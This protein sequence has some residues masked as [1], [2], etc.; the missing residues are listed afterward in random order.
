MSLVGLYPCSNVSAPRELSITSAS[1]CSVL[2]LTA[3]TGNALV[4]L[5]VIIDPNRNLRSPFSF[6]VAN[7]AA[8]DLIVGIFALPMSVEFY[9]RESKDSSAIVITPRDDARRIG[10]FISTT[11]SLFSLAALTVDRF[12]A[13]TYPMKYRAKL[14]PQRT[15]LVSACLWICAI[16]FPFLYFEVG[17]LKYQFVF[18][19][20][21]VVATFIVLCL[22]YAR[23]FKSFKNEVQRWD[24]FNGD[25]EENLVKMRALKWEK[26]VTKTFLVMLTLFIACFF[27]SLLLIYIISFCGACNCIFIHWARDLNYILIMANSSMNPFVFAWRLRTYRRAFVKILSC[28]GIVERI[29]NLSGVSMTWTGQY[30]VSMNSLAGQ[31]STSTLSPSNNVP[32]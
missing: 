9:I 30:A 6:L 13:I 11:A 23:V 15:A 32:T 7:L 26:K 27:P 5:A 21:A 22:T 10:S 1:L 14:C 4:L 16:S 12:V 20:T 17:Y 2:S 28:G 25:T 18:A 24:S 8:A 29:E 3:I 31:T 19:N